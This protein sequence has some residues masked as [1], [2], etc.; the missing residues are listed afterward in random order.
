MLSI[1]L[2]A[3]CGTPAI[4]AVENKRART[5]SLE[6][7]KTPCITQSFLLADV[8][9]LWREFHCLLRCCHLGLDL[10]AGAKFIRASSGNCVTLLEISVHFNQIPNARPSCDGY[11][12]D[13]AIVYPNDEGGFSGG[14]DAS[15]KNE[16]RESRTPN[17]P[18]SL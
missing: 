5:V 4:A 8:Q 10:S 9:V 6:F 14:H 16:H 18:A 13:D 12:L 7:A 1:A 17:W 3:G 15:G 11:P 2:R